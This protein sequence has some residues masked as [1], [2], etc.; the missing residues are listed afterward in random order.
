MLS[1]EKSPGQ[2]AKQYGVHPNSFGVWKKQFLER[3]SE[4]LAQENAAHEYERR[5]AELEQLLGTK[6]VD[7]KLARI[8]WPTTRKEAHNTSPSPVERAFPPAEHRQ[9]ERHHPA[10]RPSCLFMLMPSRNRRTTS[11][12]MR[13]LAWRQD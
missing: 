12:A 6:E 13:E 7:L 3:G 5:L 1:G 9:E 2:I 8:L 4:I 11:A 10:V